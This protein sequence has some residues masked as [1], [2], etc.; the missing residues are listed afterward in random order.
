VI[1]FCI[2]GYMVP[3]PVELTESNQVTDARAV[4]ISQLRCAS[5]HA[6]NP[7][8][9]AFPAAPAGILLETAEQL[10]ASKARILPALQTSYMPLGN[11]TQMTDEERAEMII[12]SSQGAETSKM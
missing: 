8:S 9:A 12:W 11:M 4:E 3:K 2:V 6:A 1:L 5:C 10:H 7:T